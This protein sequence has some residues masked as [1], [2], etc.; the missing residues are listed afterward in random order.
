MLSWILIALAIA[1]IFGVIKVEDIK[2][3]S[4]KLWAYI[5]K[6]WQELIVAGSHKS[7]DI[8]LISDQKDSSSRDD[9][10]TDDTTK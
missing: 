9:N 8:K 2:D 3:Q 5:K 6:L 7:A 1:I 10:H 4:L